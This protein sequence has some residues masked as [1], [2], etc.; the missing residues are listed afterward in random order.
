MNTAA[1]ATEPASTQP[2][3]GRSNGMNTAPARPAMPAAGNTPG[4]RA[5]RRHLGT[6]TGLGRGTGNAEP[7]GG[8]G[9]IMGGGA[10]DGGLIGTLDG[11]DH[12]LGAVG[13]VADGV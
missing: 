13:G 8:T 2:I 5:T 12:T 9:G 1:A 11:L 6:C 10:L 3:P 7:G 4:G